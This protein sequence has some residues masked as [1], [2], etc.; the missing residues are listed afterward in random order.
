MFKKRIFIVFL[1][2]FL[3][4]LSENEVFSRDLTLEQA[5]DMAFEN[6]IDWIISKKNIESKI[7]QKKI[8]KG[9]LYPKLS[10]SSSYSRNDGDGRRYSNSVS[11]RQDIYNRR[12]FTLLKRTDMYIHHAKYSDLKIKNE[13]VLEVKRAFYSILELKAL[14]VVFEDAVKREEEQLKYAENLF[15]LN[16]VIKTDVLRAE[17]S[18]E[19]AKQNLSTK[20]NGIKSAKMLLNNVLGIALEEE[21][22]YVP[23]S[24]LK[25]DIKKIVEGRILVHENISGVLR[26]RPEL[27]IKDKE[28]EIAEENITLSRDGYFPVVSGSGSYGWSGD[29]LSFDDGSWQAGINLSWTLF[30]GN[31]RRN[32]VLQSKLEKN[33]IEDEQKK[34]TDAVVFE[35]KKIY[36]DIEDALSLIKIFSRSLEI[37]EQNYE[38]VKNQY[39]NGLVSNLNVIDA[40][41]VYTGAEI[42]LLNAYYNYKIKL[43]ELDKATGKNL[44]EK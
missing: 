10:V 35:I 20:Y 27:K 14:A 21:F 38:L 31:V 5:V 41:S 43:A 30:D 37:A 34:L 32:E 2:M 36:L 33:K 25:E 18:L 44:P 28:I 1:F 42:D 3:I 40:E 7:L 16:K 8:S 26:N 6:N 17:I 9:D 11:L 23:E 24:N 29:E 12:N 39:Q 19:K 4:G 22:N 13:L 15:R